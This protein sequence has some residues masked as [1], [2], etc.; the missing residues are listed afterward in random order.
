MKTLKTCIL[1]VLSLIAFNDLSA[2]DKWSIELRPGVN[3][4]TQ[5]LGN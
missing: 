2:K 3:F 5:D 1:I 4:V